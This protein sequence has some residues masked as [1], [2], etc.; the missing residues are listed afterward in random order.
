MRPCVTAAEFAAI[1]CNR[2]GACCTRFH[3]AEDP[4]LALARERGLG[5]RP[6]S[7]GYVRDLAAIA[8]MVEHLEDDSSGGA[9]YRCRHFQRDETGRGCCTIHARRPQM[10]RGFPY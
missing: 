2:C 6:E 5:S 8:A 9:W 3:L 10:C 1:S 7:D 4:R